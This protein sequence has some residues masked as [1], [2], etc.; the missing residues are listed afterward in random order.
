MRLHEIGVVHASVDTR[1]VGEEVDVLEI[2]RSKR[3]EQT[4]G[5][6][7]MRIER[8]ELLLA[9]TLLSPSGAASLYPARL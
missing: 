8:I 6:I 3:I 5:N 4:Y 2:P 9:M 1:G 7:R